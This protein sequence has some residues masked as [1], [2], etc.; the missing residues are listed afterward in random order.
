[1]KLQG[2][3][4]RSWTNINWFSESWSNPPELSGVLGAYYR[5]GRAGT[6]PSDGTFVETLDRLDGLSV[7]ADGKH[8][9]YLW[10]VDRA[11]NA[12]HL[13]RNVDP[14]VFWYDGTPPSSSLKLD[15]PLPPS[16]WYST[17]V[18]ATLTGQ[19][20]PG[21]SGLKNVYYSI[22]ESPWLTGSPP[23]LAAEGEHTLAYYA[24]DKAGNAEPV[25]VVNWAIDQ[26][27]PA[28]TLAAD[29]PPTATG[30]YTAPV[31]FTLTAS[32]ALSGDARAYYRLDGGPWQEADALTFSAEGA[33]R[34]EYT[35]RDL[36][37][38]QAPVRA[39]DAKLDTR[40]PST[41]YRVQGTPGAGGW[42]V[43]PVTVSLIAED[44][45]S[46]VAATFYRVGAAPWQQGDR[47]QLPDDG[48]Y[49]VSFYS[50]D[51][52]GNV[53]T[54]FP[55]QI[56]VD[57][58]VPSAPKAVETI[59]AGWSRENR[60]SVTWATPADLSGVVGVHYQLDREPAA[61]DDGFY[62]PY[63]DR[64]DGLSVPEEGIHRLY[65][66]LRD[67]AGN[68]DHNQRSLAP[69]LRYDGTPP[70]TTLKVAGLA[71]VNGWYRSAVTVTLTSAD[72]TSGLK[73]MRYRLDAGAWVQTTGPASFGIS[74]PDKHVLEF[75][76]EDN[77][78]NVEPLQVATIRIDLQAP[79]SA[80]QVSS[81]PPGW[82]HANQFRLS[83]RSPVDQ[84]GV[85]GVYV[86]FDRPPAG[87]QD[88]EFYPGVESA[89][90]LQVPSEGKHTAYVW[91]RDGAGNSDHRT[92][93]AV[94]DALWYDATSP[95][96]T[97][98]VAGTPG[99]NG[100][101]VSTV[102]LT[103]TANDAGSGPAKVRYQVNQ[104]PWVELPGAGGQVE[105]AHEG[106]HLV[107]MVAVDV[108]GNS[109]APVEKLAKIDLQPPTA[110]LGALERYQGL[111]SFNVSW[112]AVDYASGV[113]W[114][115]VQVRDN[116]DGA[117]ADWIP[118]TGVTTGLYPGQR[119]HSYCFRVRGRDRAGNLQAYGEAQGCTVTETVKNGGFDTG[120]FAEWSTSGVLRKAV[121]P[122]ESPWGAP[123]QLARLGTPDYGP[124]IE[125]PGTVPVGAATVSQTVV[126][127]GLNVMATPTLNF[128]YRIYSHDVMYSERLKQPVDT[129][130]ATLVPASGVPNLLLLDGNPANS[131]EW[132]KCCLGQLYDSGW[133]RAIIDMRPYAGQT[134]QLSFSSYNRVDNLFNTWSFVDAIQL[135]D[136]PFQ[137]RSALPDLHRQKAAAAAEAMVDESVAAAPALPSSQPS[138]AGGAGLR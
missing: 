42:Y 96:A 23:P 114:Y 85:S 79:P 91:L 110:R 76:S 73:Q 49:S 33:H 121:V 5:F 69:L 17:T 136:Y 133:K 126:V 60:F 112:F 119:G 16:G 10:L 64:L 89:D 130:E 129:F 71:G 35:A 122:A 93:V 1:M 66:W 72:P 128:W 104:E 26:T 13:N 39:L 82:Q 84:S 88:G 123:D 32:D 11:G 61:P 45:A 9:L 81:A 53:E 63:T 103:L 48:V 4:A 43:S 14:Q 135:Q 36:A 95:S 118:Q 111:P 138:Q 77:A 19:D 40:S 87:P 83:W 78:G 80:Q 65:L 30:W 20:P 109:S 108:A 62:S 99:L 50:Q 58:T 41:A 29:R 52:A 7:P 137:R 116:L 56:M 51:R 47:F 92:A 127:P 102:R 94:K 27:A 113:E 75:Q 86:R 74:T 55:V 12:N 100:W 54:S 105:L 124:S 117:W 44:A 101:Y 115:D 38:N 15:P 132:V 2:S 8:D 106:Q 107:R 134:V 70:V 37:G 97:M 21:G 67:A 25:R 59:P 28:V 3:P 6:S 31:T 131:S 24:E 98:S 125:D 34:I 90:G 68:V 22:D 120:T 57:A 18:Q 46:G